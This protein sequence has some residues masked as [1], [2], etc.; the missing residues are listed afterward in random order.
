MAYGDS[1]PGGQRGSV[2][3]TRS[4]VAGHGEHVVL[5]LIYV[6]YLQLCICCCDGHV[7]SRAPLLENRARDGARFS[8]PEL[9]FS[10]TS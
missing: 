5:E 6:V 2:K 1:Y 8:F 7:S 3:L 4:R 10:S 9:F